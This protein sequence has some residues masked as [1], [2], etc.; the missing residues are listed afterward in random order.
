MRFAAASEKTPLSTSGCC[1]AC[2]VVVEVEL[3]SGKI[4][5]AQCPKMEPRVHPMIGVAK[6][7]FD[8]LGSVRDIFK[9]INDRAMGTCL[10]P[11]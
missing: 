3:A 9:L 1:F 8:S 2:P 4:N 6:A 10:L 11:L 7:R 5:W